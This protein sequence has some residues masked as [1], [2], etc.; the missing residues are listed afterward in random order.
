MQINVSDSVYQNQDGNWYCCLDSYLPFNHY[1]D[2]DDYRDALLSYF[3]GNTESIF[4][5][6]NNLQFNPF[7]LN[8]TESVSPLLD[9]DP[10]LNFF[11]DMSILNNV[12]N[13]E[14]YIEDSFNRKCTELNNIGTLFSVFHL[15]IRSAP[16]H[17]SDLEILLS[18]LDWR[19]SVIG[20]CETW[21]N[22]Q[23]VDCYGLDGYN[24]EHQF[25]KDRR[26]GGVS[27]FIDSR[28]D[29]TV[30][31]DLNIQ[32]DYI[33]SIFIE[34]FKSAL[35]VE[36]NIIVGQIYRPPNTD[37]TMFNE[38][39][40]NALNTVSCESKQLYLLGDFNLNLLN[41]E[42]HALTSEFLEVLYASS[43]F[44]L[45]TKPTRVHS[46]SATLID[47]ILFNSL[48]NSDHCNGIIFS[49]ISDHFPIFSI[50]LVNV[51]ESIKLKKYR[52]FSSA[53]IG[54]F[55]DSLRNADWSYI[56]VNQNCQEAF[57][58]FYDL[59]KHL[60]DNC[61]PVQT[62][63]SCYYSRKYW[64]SAGLKTSIKLKNRL[65]LKSK[66]TPTPSN[67]MK[68]KDY[69]NELNRLLRIA[70]REHYDKLLNENK[71][72]LKKS[73]SIIKSV[74]NKNKT[75]K[76]QSHFV[77]NDQ[78]ISN[79]KIIANAFNEYYVNIGRTLAS[80]IEVT[81]CDPLSYINLDIQE[82]LC[83]YDTNDQEI[84]KIILGL[85]EGS[86]GYDAIIAKIIKSSF[87]IYLD[88]LVHLINLSLHQGVF[89]SELKIAKVI[90]IYKSSNAHMISNYR[91]VSLLS[92]FS[93]IYEKIMYARLLNFINQRE[94]LYKFQFGFRKDHNTSLALMILLD[95]ISNAFNCNEMVLGVF[96]DFRK[97]FDTVNHDILLK[98]LYKYGIRGVSHDWIKSYLSNRKQFVC[99]DECD[100]TVLPI[101]C[102]VPQG[103]ILGPL[104]FILYINDLSNISNKFFPV[105]FAD[106]SNLF[107][108]GKNL[109]EMITT[110]NEE[111]SKVYEW[112]VTNK[113]S[114]NVD[115][116]NFIL[117]STNR[118]Q[119]LINQ[120]V[121]IKG[122][123]IKQVTSTK[124]LGVVIDSKL[125]WSEHIAM[126]KNKVSKGLG[127]IYK[128]KKLLK[129]ETLITLYY[130][131]IYPYLIYCIENWGY[132]AK[133]HMDSLVKVQKRIIRVI[134][135]SNF[136]DHTAP[137]FT[138][139]KILP[140]AKLFLYQILVFM[141]KVYC[142][143]L[144][145]S[146]LNMFTLNINVH[147]YNT[148]SESL[149]QLPYMRLSISQKSI[150][151]IG[152]KIWNY[153]SRIDDIFACTNIHSFKKNVRKIVLVSDVP[154]L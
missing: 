52:N 92:N 85:K 20:L 49:D 45:I 103:S 1:S 106:D 151:F 132:A 19:F 125:K 50:K 51:N 47:N 66:R 141:Y 101:T 17:M 118:R 82:S 86:A 109:N 127:I 58:A 145:F 30:R 114:L 97:A 43:V 75:K 76:M 55:L 104:L 143:L 63:K 90:P 11:N 116:T 98:K 137:L 15:N 94:V 53:N 99:F 105:L 112:L 91:P 37:V 144:P 12:G 64:L 24:G 72:N 84:K 25:R 138:K 18:H 88:S 128:A 96:L 129:W 36:K 124:F 89:P 13:C 38:V 139:L 150:K 119:H 33:E 60:Y 111:L 22:D 107:F 142:K 42:Q 87:E 61:F 4:N 65:F 71:S 34:I 28:L 32:D 120:D 44:P 126:V 6:L 54:K 21:F 62:V 68:Y 67:I 59:F 152:P 77:I 147:S 35:G 46:T 134:S 9:V 48:E 110:I 108:R 14:Y 23:N 146:L 140:I 16:K 3:S 74:I 78:N 2:D 93:K 123:K 122:T 26:G 115:K 29:Y 10:D 154:N 31:T 27:L 79:S 133:I 73:W 136:R 70:E 39:I 95:E 149:F 131:F 100:S 81:N 7:Q 5:H 57:T 113:L 8:E 40:S 135:S 80:N 121:T 130:S 41:C 117:F 148:R 69:R 102:G 153:Y 83:L 56:L